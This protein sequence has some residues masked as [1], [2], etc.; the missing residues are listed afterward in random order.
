[1][2]TTLNRVAATRAARRSTFAARQQRMGL[3]FVLPS[4]LFILVFF[5]I[6]LIMAA[7]VSLHNWPLFG[8]QQFIGLRNYTTL[9]NDA[10]FWSSLR[11]T[12]QYALLVTPGIFLLGFGMALLVN[13]P[14]RG[15]GL[16]RTAFFLPNVI[17]FGAV[18]LMWYFMLNNE[19]GIINAL[20]R[21]LG[22]IS[23]SLLWLANYNTAMFAIILMV[24]WK[25]AGGT[26]LLLLIG[27]Q[28][29]PDELY[30]AAKVDGANAWQ[31]LRYIM[32]PLLKRTFALALVLSVTGSFLA[33]D[34]FYILTNGG[35]QNQTISVVYRIVNTAFISFKIGY[36]TAIS[37]V[38]LFILVILNGVQLFLLREPAH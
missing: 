4:V 35:P 24:V 3:L 38:L 37:I 10:Q 25:T 34:Q 11:F 22:I 36:A 27:M 19:L 21:Q 26:M 5:A 31:R 7:W 29:I 2:A 14:L 32:L 13:R 15:V 8:K 9:F 17:G 16:F 28:G 20:L 1:M 23:G 6:P 30:E 18:C 12:A 33:F